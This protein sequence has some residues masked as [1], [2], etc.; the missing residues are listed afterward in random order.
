MIRTWTTQ[1]FGFCVDFRRIQVRKTTK[2]YLSHTS[3]KKRNVPPHIHLISPLSFFHFFCNIIVLK[4]I[5]DMALEK[6]RCTDPTACYHIGDSI[7]IDVVGASK[8]GWTPL[9]FNEW[10]DE[11]FPDWL[12]TGKYVSIM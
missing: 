6:A 9:R 12:D 8:A 2:R 5:F 3:N 10:F 1:A 11:D 4:A 7:D